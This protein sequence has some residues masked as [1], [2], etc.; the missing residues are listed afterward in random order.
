MGF[1][2]TTFRFYPAALPLSYSQARL[3]EVSQH[4]A[5]QIL[6]V[7]SAP[8]SPPLGSNPT[9]RDYLES[10]QEVTVSYAAQNIS[11]ATLL[12]QASQVSLALYPLSYTHLTV[13]GWIRTND[14]SL[15]KK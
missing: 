11:T 13:R 3:R 7:Q 1:E 6:G 12:E 10:N 5:A 2:P 4:Y 9:V 8:G 14:L 15:D